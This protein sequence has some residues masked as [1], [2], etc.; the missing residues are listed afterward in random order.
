MHDFQLNLS[1]APR[2]KLV[3]TNAAPARLSALGFPRDRPR[4]ALTTE[5][6]FLGES[7]I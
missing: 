7:Q 5:K 2:A 6:K 1:E 4:G 3:G